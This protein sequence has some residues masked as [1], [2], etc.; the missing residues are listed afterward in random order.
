MRKKNFTF[1]GLYRANILKILKKVLIADVKWSFV[2]DHKLKNN[3]NSLK[4]FFGEQSLHS[5]HNEDMLKNML[6]N[7][8]ANE[9]RI[10]AVFNVKK[11][12]Y[13]DKIL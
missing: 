5:L 7:V 2:T 10:H 1:I 11:D 4:Q 12:L 8:I 6:V 9:K 13:S 3:N